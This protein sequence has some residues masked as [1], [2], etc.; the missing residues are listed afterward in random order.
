MASFAEGAWV[1]VRDEDH[2]CLAVRAT[3]AFTA[4]ESAVVVECEDGSEQTLTG[5]QTEHASALDPQVLDG[6][7]IDDLI[8]LS[9]LRA[10][11]L[12]HILRTRFSADS[13]YTCIGS[14]LLSVNP[15]KPLPLF[16][17]QILSQ[18]L[19]SAAAGAVG[20]QL[21]PHIYAI[22][23][24]AWRNVLNTGKP[25]S[26]VCSGESGAGKTEA[27]K[28]ILQC[29]TA[30]ARGGGAAA[31]RWA[32]SGASS[33]PIRWWRLSATPRPRATTTPRVSASS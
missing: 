5:A 11:A 25:Q 6:G 32:S 27:T 9:D 22:G 10:E 23:A 29:L 16:T 26:V 4:G 19:R 8:S 31:A 30:A 24:Q 33:A 20:G 14:I 17:P 3:H 12:L 21:A 2:F 7:A 13:I 15:F 1:W 28:L 18:H